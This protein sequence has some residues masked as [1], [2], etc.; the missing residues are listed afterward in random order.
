M[1]TNF[2][3][4]YEAIDPRRALLGLGALGGGLYGAYNLGNL[5]DTVG[6]VD[7]FLRMS[8]NYAPGTRNEMYSMAVKNPLKAIDMY[9]SD[10]MKQQ[11]D[12]AQK[13]LEHNRS[14]ESNKDMR[15]QI[16]TALD[17][18]K[19]SRLAGSAIG[20]LAGLGLGGLAGAGLTRLVIG[21][22]PSKQKK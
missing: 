19:R 12:N 18:L 8:D 13:D 6:G 9:T 10:E 15:Y 14:T 7:S 20:G 5:G 3:L 2:E 17:D 4:I 21:K 11:I 1:I 16:N 22:D